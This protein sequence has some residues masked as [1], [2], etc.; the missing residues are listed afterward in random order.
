MTH[1]PV[2]VLTAWIIRIRLE[3]GAK[4]NKPNHHQLTTPQPHYSNRVALVSSNGLMLLILL[5]QAWLGRVR[6]MYNR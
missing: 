5:K 6:F 3:D 2:M 4:V 1:I